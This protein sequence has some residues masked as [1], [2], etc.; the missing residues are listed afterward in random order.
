MHQYYYKGILGD[1]ASI[2]SM[3]T[4]PQGKSNRCLTVF[5]IMPEEFGA[6]SEAIQQALEEE[7]IEA[8]PVWKPMHLQP[9]FRF[10]G[11]SSKLKAA[12]SYK[13]IYNASPGEIRFAFHGVKILQGR[14][15][16]NKITNAF[17]RAGELGIKP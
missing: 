11:H 16:L 10:E 2:E 13:N 17:N 7:N 5:L 12:G 9:V 3:S 14:P 4:A 15:R 1:I 6:D 8:R